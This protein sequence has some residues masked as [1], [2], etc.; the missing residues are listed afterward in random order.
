MTKAAIWK[1]RDGGKASGRQKRSYGCDYELSWLKIHRPKRGRTKEG[2]EAREFGDAIASF[3]KTEFAVL[4]NYVRSTPIDVLLLKK[5]KGR[6][7]GGGHSSLCEPEWEYDKRTGVIRIVLKDDG[8]EHVI[9]RIY[10]EPVKEEVDYKQIANRQIVPSKQSCAGMI[11]PKGEIM[12]QRRSKVL[13]SFS[14]LRGNDKAL[15]HLESVWIA[16]GT[17][18]NLQDFCL[19]RNMNKSA[20]EFKEAV[21]VDL[22]IPELLRFLGYSPT[23]QFTT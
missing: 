16:N 19:R 10:P 9:H 1:L 2:E 7:S 21:E 12:A 5:M 11:N 20:Q 3:G 13:K 18:R 14:R 22:T 4:D 6:L 17:M 23:H 15:R 8:Y